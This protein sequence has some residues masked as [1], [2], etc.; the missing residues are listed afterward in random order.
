M[1]V[2]PHGAW[3]RLYCPWCGETECLTARAMRL[4]ARRD[5]S[6]KS[7][8]RFAV[9]MACESCHHLV[10]LRLYESPAGASLQVERDDPQADAAEFSPPR[11]KPDNLMSC[12]G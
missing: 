11:D 2:D 8:L 1:E 9:Q 12:G 6:L 5:P 7:E 3:Q 4:Y 10:R